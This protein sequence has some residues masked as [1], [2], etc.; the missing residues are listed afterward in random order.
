MEFKSLESNR[1][2]TSHQT[3]IEPGFEPI[4]PPRRRISKRWLGLLS[5]F[6]IVGGGYWVYQRS[7]PAEPPA[8]QRPTVVRVERADLAVTV[9]SNGT[10][11]PEQLVNISPKTTGIMTQL[12]V[13]EGDSV[14][15]GQVIAYMDDSNL[16]GQMTQ[17]QGQLAKAKAD[18]AKMRAGNR[19]EEI[20]QAQAR[21]ESA[22]ADLRLAEEDLRRNQALFESGAIARQAYDKARTTRDTAQ[23]KLREEEQAL[24]L[25]QAGS[26]VEDIAAAEAAV[27]TAAGSLQTIQAQIN[28]TVVRAPFS[29]LVSRK[30]AD[31]G[32]FVAPT[33]AGSS[34]SSATSSSILS[35]ASA[36]R[37]VANVAENRISQIK[38]GQP[39]TITADAYPG[40]T[41]EGKVSQI[42]T[43]AIVEQNVTSFEVKVALIGTTAKALRSG[44]N[45]S[46]KFN[47]GQ[48][49][50]VLTVPTV[51]V[52][53]KD[54][55]TGVFV[56]APK[57]PPRFIPITT[58]ITIDNRTEVKSGLT[59]TEHILI[60]VPTKP[61]QSGFSFSDLF[62]GGAK[63]GPPGGGPPGGPP[64]GGGK[65][66]G[67]PPG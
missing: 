8:G 67:P 36:N 30:Y 53:R 1:P 56:G 51:A 39:V 20:G 5:L 42:A 3:L 62:G 21:L 25:S 61:P 22:K 37:V 18:L 46:A 59:G 23:A 9:S 64:G 13:K 57:Q 15:Q 17:A 54:Q 12:L 45:V 65:P 24:S 14:S 38:L 58:G 4:A 28:D 26:R 7:A 10:V 48:L 31:P 63:D 60:N 34:V 19:V 40:K 50:N 35:L 52:T 27:I 11:E 6:L 49:E 44:M 41:F 33:T 32:A 29:G 66:S 16:Q 55:V 2:A 43:Q 47:V